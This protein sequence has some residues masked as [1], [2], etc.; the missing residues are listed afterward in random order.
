MQI[1]S[2][3][4]SIDLHSQLSELTRLSDFLDDL[5]EAWGLSEDFL[6]GVHVAL[7]EV[8]SNTIRHGYDDS[9]HHRIRILVELAGSELVMRVEDDA[10]EF[11]P[12]TVPEPDL[13]VPLKDRAVGG[14]GIFLVR[15]LMDSV[16]YERRGERNILTLS[17]KLGT[18]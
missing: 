15:K 7:D 17:K 8:V 6:H 13:T 2:R 16:S 10:A 14:L 9:A 12:L 5:A 3:R 1:G 18:S 11:N 4:E